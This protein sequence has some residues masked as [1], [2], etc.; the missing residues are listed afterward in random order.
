MKN[1]LIEKGF[2]PEPVGKLISA[3]SK[4]PF[5]LD[6]AEKICG[7]MECITNLRKIMEVANSLADGIR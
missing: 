7:E 1:E 3:I 4:E 6:D 5:T 2:E